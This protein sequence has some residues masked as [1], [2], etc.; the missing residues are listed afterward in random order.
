M[1]VMKIKCCN[2]EN[3]DNNLENYQYVQ[4][5]THSSHL[6]SCMVAKFEINFP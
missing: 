6:S 1:L 2:L 5:H 3:I 4:N